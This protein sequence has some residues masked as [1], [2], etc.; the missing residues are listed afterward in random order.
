[1]TECEADVRAALAF[2]TPH[3]SFYQLTLE[4]NTVFAKSRHRCRITI[5]RRTSTVRV[6]QLLGDAGYEHYGNLSLRPAGG[7]A[8]STTLNY[9]GFGDYVAI[10]AGAHGSRPR[11]AVRRAQGSRRRSC[12]R[13]G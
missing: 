7:G 8:A 5:W 11:R 13:N 12:A 10:G 9:W 2:G 4:P 6:E 3:L 1:M